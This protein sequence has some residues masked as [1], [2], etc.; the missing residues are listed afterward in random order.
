MRR[1]CRAVSRYSLQSRSAPLSRARAG[2]PLRGWGRTFAARA[3]L[4]E[5]AVGWTS[6]HGRGHERPRTGTS[7]DE[8]LARAD[9]QLPAAAGIGRSRALRAGVR[10]TGS[11]WGSRGAALTRFAKHFAH[12]RVSSKYRAKKSVTPAMESLTFRERS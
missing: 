5:H 3:P 6:V 4:V 9:S 11:Q 2:Q 12:R 10:R 1:I 7:G 8:I